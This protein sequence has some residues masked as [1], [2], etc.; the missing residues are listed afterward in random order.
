[1]RDDSNTPKVS[2]IVP[3]YNT[4]L[5]LVE[6]INSLIGQTY[7]NIEI[8][9][10]DDGSTDKSGQICDDYSND[11]D[12]IK[13]I[14][15]ENEGLG[16]ARNTGLENVHGQYVYFQDSDDY[17]DCDIIEKLVMAL[18]EN[19][20]DVCL[21]G[22]KVIDD[23]KQIKY[24][25]DYKDMVYKGNEV[26][27]VLL[28]KML[29]S[30][31]D[32]TDRIEMSASAQLY[33]TKLIMEHN[34]R[35]VSEKKYISEDLVFNIDYMQYAKVAITISEIGY[36]YRVNEYS[37]SHQYRS[38]R[39]EKTIFFYSFILDRL[40]ELGFSKDDI[41]RHTKQ[42]FIG[43]RSCISQERN[44]KNDNLKKKIETIHKLCA[45]EVLKC[46]IKAYPVKLLGIKQRFF[47]FLINNNVS[48]LLYYLA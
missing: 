42:F 29:G 34:L 19:D 20:A 13:V 1:M 17:I 45:N 22:F 41:N 25:S 35:F 7:S 10:I 21:T 31:P 43:V 33:S 37:L 47:L 24:R 44:N 48:I 23:C 30:L 14:H 3:V 9:L 16:M 5:Y 15:K 8:I 2:I 28:P 36:Y 11:Y 27:F 38:D 6:C 18:K 12:F 46:A 39:I 32:G 40:M 4:E 26:K